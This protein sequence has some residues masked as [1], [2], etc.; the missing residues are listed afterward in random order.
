MR[1]FCFTGTT[2]QDL[3]DFFE[4]VCHNHRIKILIINN[5][6]AQILAHQIKRRQAVDISPTVITVPD[7]GERFELE[8]DPIMRRAVNIIIDYKKTPG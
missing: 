8:N 5:S 2:K 7:K 3:K 4:R 1:Y 6:S